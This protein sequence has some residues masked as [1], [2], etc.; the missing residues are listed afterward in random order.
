MGLERMT[1]L[2]RLSKSESKHPKSLKQVTVKE[3]MS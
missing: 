3:P 1:I 2:S